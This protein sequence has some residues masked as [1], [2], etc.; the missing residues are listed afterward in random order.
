MSDF[1]SA[2][3]STFERV[4]GRAPAGVWAAPGRV[5]LIGEYTDINEGWVLPLALPHT[6]RVAAAPREDGRLRLHRGEDPAAGWAGVAAVQAQP[7]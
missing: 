7:P 1:G 4:F 2:F 6:V 3:G 5:N